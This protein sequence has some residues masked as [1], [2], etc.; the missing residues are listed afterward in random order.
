VEPEVC[1]VL[2]EMLAA[3][4]HGCYKIDYVL[5]SFFFFFFSKKKKPFPAKTLGE[6]E[7]SQYFVNIKW[8]SV[9]DFFF[10]FFYVQAA[11]IRSDTE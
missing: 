6:E 3:E 7:T 9:E 5:C 1:W 8:V 11:F 4:K 10:F 2:L